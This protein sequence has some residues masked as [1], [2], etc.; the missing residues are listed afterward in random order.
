MDTQGVL[1]IV[2][3]PIG[4]MGDITLRAI[5][6]LKSVDLIAAED[7]RHSK[8]LLSF[9]DIKKDMLSLHEHNEAARV[10][11]I[12][13]LLDSGKSVALISDAGTPLIND[14]GYRLVASLRSN[15]YT[16]VPIPGACALISALSVSGMPTDH[17]SFMGFLPNKRVARIK[18]LERHLESRETLICYEAPHRL[19]AL[20][21][22][23]QEVFGP[24]RKVCLARE[25]TK[26]FETIRTEPV[27]VLKN[28]VETDKNQ[29]RGECVV[30]IAGKERKAVAQGSDSESFEL[31]PQSS[32]LM[33]LLEKE[34][35][36]KK[37]AAIVSEMS[38][39]SKKYLY[40][41][42]IT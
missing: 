23:V 26:N 3:T 9:Y 39:I 38:G 14:P 40:K 31:D 30:L 29:Q 10:S 32:R 8:K 18:H 41:L 33:A 21:E 11:D 6:V 13:E 42:L 16:I 27:E 7:T 25:M 28:W 15:A 22:D 34:L 1:Y 12:S 4:N 20:L 5:E 24:Q 17:F 2:S 37:T 36:P 19:L 35:P